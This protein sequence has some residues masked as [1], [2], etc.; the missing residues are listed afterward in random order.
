MPFKPPEAKQIFK[1]APGVILFMLAAITSTYLYVNSKMSFTIISPGIIYTSTTIL[2]FVITRKITSI[3][4]LL[5]Y[6]CLMITTYFL[7]WIA[8][9]YSAFFAFIAGILTAGAGALISFALADKF[10][11]RLSFSKRNIFIIGAASFLITDIFIFSFSNAFDKSPIQ[12]IFNLEYSDRTLYAE[13]IFFWQLLVGAKLVFT[14]QK[15]AKQ[16]T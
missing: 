3:L 15:I 8:T 5:L 1:I 2:V 7:I 11:T 14:L 12:Y 9:L 4:S 10:V 13:V 16:D 6:Y